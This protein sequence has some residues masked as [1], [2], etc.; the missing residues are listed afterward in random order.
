MWDLSGNFYLTEDDIG[1]NRALSCCNKLQELNVVVT[2]F[3]LT[4][5]ITE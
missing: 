2:V 5:E 3:T 1:K 4:L